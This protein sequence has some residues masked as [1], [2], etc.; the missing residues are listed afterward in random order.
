VK[1]G[2]QVQGFDVGDPIAPQEPLS[3]AVLDDVRAS[4]QDAQGAPGERMA[5]GG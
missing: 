2:L 1:A 5:R 4:L 3:P